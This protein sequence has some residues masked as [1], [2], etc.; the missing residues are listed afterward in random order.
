MEQEMIDVE[1]Y[2]N[3]DE[4]DLSDVKY[5]QRHWVADCAIEVCIGKSGGL[6]S[7]NAVEMRRCY[8]TADNPNVERF[9][10]ITNPEELVAIANAALLA[11]EK[12]MHLNAVD[13]ELEQ[14]DHEK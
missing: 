3:T 7:Q 12:L 1:L 6:Q 10:C 4:S 8:P 2:L 11:W 13:S 5:K 9:W 14:Q